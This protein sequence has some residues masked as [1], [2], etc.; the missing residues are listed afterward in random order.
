MP[1]PR[2]VARVN[3]VVTN[4]VTVLFAGWVPGFG[5]VLHQGRRSNRPYRTPINVFRLPDGYVV[6]LTYGPDADWVKNVVAGNGCV[7][8]VGRRPV[9]LVDPRIVHDETRHDIP[10]VVRQIL[11]LLRVTDFLYLANESDEPE[12]R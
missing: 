2:I 7:L 1:I 10:P 11:G 4:R 5:V 8:E 9:R 6:A 3:R 12:Q